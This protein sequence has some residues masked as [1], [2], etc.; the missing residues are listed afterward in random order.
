MYARTVPQVT[1]H[2]ALRKVMMWPVVVV[3]SGET[4]AEVVQALAAD[5]V[6]AVCVTDD[7]RLVGIVSE[8]DVVAHLAQGADP[9]HLSA[10]EVMNTELVVA[11][12]DEPVLEAARR[13]EQA[14]VRH[15][16]VLDGDLICGIVSIRDLFAVLL[17]DHAGT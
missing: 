10:G 1:A 13:M 4:L 8:R 7:G 14:Q 9:A 3:E 5:E 11:A 16:P 17:G 12:P 2:T 6:G 15:L